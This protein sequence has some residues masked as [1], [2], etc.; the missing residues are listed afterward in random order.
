MIAIREFH[1]TM[2]AISEE[3]GATDFY[4]ISSLRELGEVLA[5]RENKKLVMVVVA[6]S[7]TVDGVDKDALEDGNSTGIYLL[8]KTDARDFSS[9]LT[10]LEATQKGILKA[11][12]LIIKKEGTP[13]MPFGK[14]DY[15]SIDIEPES[16]LPGYYGYSMALSFT[17]SI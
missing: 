14:L 10:A 16:D 6:P 13:C 8:E 17:D 11:R 3:V 7:V 9:R 4:M 2:R 15:K 12:T 5:K 1:D